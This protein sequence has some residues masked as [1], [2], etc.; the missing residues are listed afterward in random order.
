MRGI[1]RTP[2]AITRASSNF[3]ARSFASGLDESHAGA[4]HGC[5][6]VIAR[7]TPSSANRM[8]AISYLLSVTQAIVLLA[9]FLG[10]FSY[11]LGFGDFSLIGC[12]LPAYAYEEDRLIDACA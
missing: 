11:A 2:E 10:R 5:T 1:E 6:I 4:Q 7:M 3:A 8:E 9:S 12:A